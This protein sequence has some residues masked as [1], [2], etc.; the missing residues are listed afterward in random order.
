MTHKKLAENSDNAANFT[1]SNQSNV[2]R[3]ELQNSQSVF[4]CSFQCDQTNL[5][6][7]YYLVQVFQSTNFCHQT[8][9]LGKSINCIIITDYSNL[10]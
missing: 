3:M 1:F 7:Q 10:F 6:F 4:F 5:L 8:E 2:L 9:L